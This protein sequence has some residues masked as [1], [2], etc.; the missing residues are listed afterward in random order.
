MK[1]SLCVRSSLPRVGIEEPVA[2]N[3]D[4][5]PDP[6]DL[7]QVDASSSSKPSSSSNGWLHIRLHRANDPRTTS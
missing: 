3:E 7:L 6:P 1:L 2:P 5:T 4:V